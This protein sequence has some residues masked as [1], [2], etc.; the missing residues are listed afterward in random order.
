MINDTAGVEW[1]TFNAAQRQAR[2]DLVPLYATSTPLMKRRFGEGSQQHAFL[3]W[4]SVQVSCI[5]VVKRE[6]CSMHLLPCLLS[7][8]KS[9]VVTGEVSTATL[10]LACTTLYVSVC[11]LHNIVT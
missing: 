7:R 5:I 3:P 2:K 6:H 10:I 1:K 4:F 11:K 8:Y 9:C